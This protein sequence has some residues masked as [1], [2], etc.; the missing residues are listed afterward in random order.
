[1][2]KKIRVL[3][4]SSLI[5]FTAFPMMSCATQEEVVEVEK[6]DKI[7]ISGMKTLKVGESC[8]LTANFEGTAKTIKWLS[9]SPEIATIS[10]E[11]VV[12]AVDEGETTIICQ[13]TEDAKVRATCQIKVYKEFED[14]TLYV[15]VTF[16]NY[17][18]TVIDQQ[19]VE[20]GKTPT[21]E[22]ATPTRISDDNN[23]YAFSGRDKEFGAVYED[24]TYIATYEVIPLSE[25]AF[26]VD[27]VNG[28][29]KVV[30][31]TGDKTEIQIPATF[32]YRKVVSIGDSA[33]ANNTKLTKV[34]LPEGLKA[35]GNK[36]FYGCKA[37][38]DM[39]IPSTVTTLG[40]SSFE[41]CSS[42]TTILTLNDNVVDIPARC[43][44]HCAGLSRIEGHKNLETIGRAAFGKCYALVF[45]FTD[46]IN[47]IDAFAF[48]S[49]RCLSY[50]ELPDSITYLGESVFCHCTGLFTL[51]L[52]AN[53]ETIDYEKGGYQALTLGCTSLYQITIDES[54]PNFMID[55]NIAIYNKDGTILYAVA[56]I[57]TGVYN[58]LDTCQEIKGSA[59][60]KFTGTG[61]N[62]PKSVTKIGTWAFWLSEIQTVTFEDGGT[63][64]TMSG[65]CFQDCDKLTTVTLPDHLTAIPNNLF[66]YTP[67]VETVN[68]S[69]KVTSIGTYVFYNCSRLRE[70]ELPSGLTS[71]GT[72]AFYNTGIED[73][74]I[75]SG[76]TVINSSVFYSCS[77]LKNVTFLGKV[78][79]IGN[80][81]FS[82]SGLE[83]FVIP[84]TVTKI[85]NYAFRFC[86][87]LK[88]I[89]LPT[90][91]SGTSAFG[92]YTF[93]SCTALEE[94]TFGPG[95]TDDELGS[96]SLT[97]PANTFRGDSNI[98]TINFRGSE[99]AFAKVTVKDST[100]LE[101]VNSGSVV[102]NYNVDME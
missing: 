37:I 24:T 77:N 38:T 50:L 4:L 70:I 74:T 27:T 99:T 83:N 3:A 66:R 89:T 31:Y 29:Y 68:F 76:V 33:F 101:L 6:T 26:A 102:I 17:D 46:K 78:T 94:I 56:P 40:E 79:S 1:M 58:V 71:I 18:G 12:Q 25:F 45:S 75:P 86:S 49:N 59:F 84:N 35:I 73:I 57:A 44:Y 39:N 97:V 90:A 67:S 19:I 61:I 82:Y 63:T 16:V 20:K 7:V 95:L 8:T 32:A 10:E 42:W 91:L 9:T 52:P 62:I 13:A 48:E 92:S 54:N 36:A 47:H 100:L 53:L 98:K 96:W 15:K 88:S 64:L 65:D 87:E 41:E 2:K 85:N 30:S 5:A 11:G 69:D 28:G 80:S 81:A 93:G 34:T 23:G 51:K 55:K 22:G 21:Y 72:Y 43:F 60:Y 14:T